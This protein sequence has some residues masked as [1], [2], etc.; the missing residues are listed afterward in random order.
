[1][2][3]VIFLNCDLVALDILNSYKKFIVTISLPFS[4]DRGTSSIFSSTG[5]LVINLHDV[6]FSSKI[7]GVHDVCF[8]K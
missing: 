6:C 4:Y 2:N 8:Y 1:M 7:Y 3:N 5:N